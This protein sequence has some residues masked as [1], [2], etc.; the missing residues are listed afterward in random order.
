[1]AAYR[2]VYDSRHLL[3]AKNLDQLRNPTLGS[4][5]WAA[6]T[7]LATIVDSDL[8]SVYIARPDETKLSRRVA[9]RRA[10]WVWY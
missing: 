6:F 5:V 8:Y 9:L 3:T 4:R 2:R 7:F 10:A 1:M